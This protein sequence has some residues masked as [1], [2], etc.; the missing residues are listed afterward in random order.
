[1]G[2]ATIITQGNPEAI[3]FLIAAAIA[4]AIATLA[5]H[6]RSVPGGPALLTMMAGEAGWA[7]CGRRVTHRQHAD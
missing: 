4:S 7:L 6:R 2:L 3:P 1:M 5:W